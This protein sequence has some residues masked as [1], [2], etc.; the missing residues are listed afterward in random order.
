VNQATDDGHG[1]KVYVNA[2]NLG[3]FSGAVQA[4]IGKITSDAKTEGDILNNIL[5]TAVQRW[6]GLEGADAGEDR[7]QV[8]NAGIREGIREVV[9]DV[10][11]GNKSLADGFFELSMPHDPNGKTA[12]LASDSSF[13]SYRSTVVLQNQ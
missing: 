5:T 2:E 11:S 8:V 3:Y 7:R 12:E 10:A 4:G 1:G 13:L 6:H 9:A